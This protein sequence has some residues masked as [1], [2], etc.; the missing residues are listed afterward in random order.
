MDEWEGRRG[1]ERPNGAALSMGDQGQ[2]GR[3]LTGKL[4][5][6]GLNGSRVK[7]GQKRSKQVNG[8]RHKRG[9]S[10][11]Q[12]KEFL[13]EAPPPLPPPHP[14]FKCLHSKSAATRIQ[15]SLTVLNSA[16]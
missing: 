9:N 11:W 1:R 13:S 3:G 12:T 15:T 4:H 7:V 16:H 2:R 6:N 8:Y 10:G 14:P 5:I